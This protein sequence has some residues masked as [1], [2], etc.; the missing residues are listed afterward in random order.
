MERETRD[1]VH[2]PYDTV[3]PMAAS[4]QSLPRQVFVTSPGMTLSQQRALDITA[5]VCSASILDYLHLVGFIDVRFALFTEASP[6]A[7]L[8]LRPARVSISQEH[9]FISI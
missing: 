9:W 1:H 2:P 4:Q 8:V 7:M 3:T 6:T 5:N